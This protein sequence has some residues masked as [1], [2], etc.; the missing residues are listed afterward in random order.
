MKEVNKRRIT[1]L[2]LVLAIFLVGG[3]LLGNM[4]SRLSKTDRFQVYPKNS[5]IGNVIDY[6]SAEYVDSIDINSLVDQT[7]PEILK[8]LDPHSVYIP[9]VDLPEFNEPL[10]GNFSGIGVQFNMQEDTVAIVN[11]IQNGP[12]EKSGILAGD[13]IVRVDDSLVAGVN[14]PS[15]DIVKMLKG[16]RGTDVSVSITRRGVEE[17]IDFTI[18]RDNIPLYSVDV[19]YMVTDDIGYI[20]ISNFSRTTYQEFIDAVNALNE[21]GLKKLILDLRDNGGGYLDAATQITDEFLEKGK[22]I[23]YTEG[24]AQP[25]RDAY[26]TSRGEL[27]DKDIVVLIDEFTASASEILAGAIQDNDRGTIVGRR[28][29]GKGLVQE[30]T[31]FSDGS[32]L[33]LTIARYYTPTGRCIQK[34]YNNGMEE[35]YHDLQARF[36]RGELLE[37]DSIRFN[38]SLQYLTPGGKI[39]YGG[40]GI[41]PDVFVPYD[42]TM[43]TPYFNRVRSRGL[44]YRFAFKY[45]D[46]HRSELLVF[47]NHVDISNYLDQQKLLTKFVEFAESQGIKRNLEEII[48]SE[49][50]IITQLKAYIA[51]N[52][53]DNPGFYP[54]IQDIDPTL[55]K[56]IEIL[57][58]LPSASKSL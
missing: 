6:I 7:I 20:K 28:S 24:R 47:D 55:Q 30:Q 10:E 25:R 15:D 31:T 17:L 33:R 44:I 49:K 14:M 37:Q 2:P 11:T 41:M 5:K 58:E 8:H 12:S 35:Y 45:T 39:V 42:T 54:I 16:K 22:L 26:A 19:H 38:D 40:G 32:A 1:F 53:I 43:L 3:M 34:P 52:I 29:F 57:S 56:G 23:V 21:Q 51:R 4:L 18:T 13:R 46:A 36:N 50:L 27:I 9:A 48:I